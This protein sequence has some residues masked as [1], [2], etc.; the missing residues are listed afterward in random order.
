MARRN[1]A[2][3]T[4]QKRL[5]HPSEKNPAD[6]LRRKK[7]ETFAK[8]FALIPD[9]RAAAIEAGY[10]RP[11]ASRAAG[12]LLSVKAMWARIQHLQTRDAEA[13][14]TQRLVQDLH[15]KPKAALAKAIAHNP[16]TGETRFDLGRL[17]PPEIATLDFTT[18]SGDGASRA[19]A[20]LKV[21]S[22]PDKTLAA[23]GRIISDPNYAPERWQKKT[24][25]DHI[26]ELAQRANNAA[27]IRSQMAALK[28]AKD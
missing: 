21:Q 6:P 24:F 2:Y 9:A 1:H 20:G 8:A 11:R 4:A 26:W 19:G 13:L 17:T 12:R 3:S 18:Q 14:T 16:F 27:P 28:D 25:K 22:N 7:H 5:R 23:L 15:L 10:P